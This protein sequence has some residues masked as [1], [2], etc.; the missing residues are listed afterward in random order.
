VLA[1]SSPFSSKI[2]FRAASRLALHVMFLSV[3]S[4]RA[5]ES[6]RAR[7]PES[8]R[9]RESE[10]ESESKRETVTEQVT[11]RVCSRPRVDGVYK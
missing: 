1:S 7:E 4:E 3:E 10:R 6:A 9:E 8:E 11:Q 5:R 2:F